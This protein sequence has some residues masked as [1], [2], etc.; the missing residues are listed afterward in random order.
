MNKKKLEIRKAILKDS[1]G[2]IEV[3]MDSAVL[4]PKDK[5]NKE[6]NKYIINGLK[7]KSFFTLVAEIDKK[8]VGVCISNI[9]R[10]NKISADL[11]D[12]YILKK[13][14][15]K[16]IGAR[17]LEK[18]YKELKKRDVKYLGL[19]SEN[20]KKTLNFYKKQGFQIGRLIRRCDK[21]L[22]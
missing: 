20:N 17:L 15:N 9:G 3:F 4:N 21:I 11:V 6:L 18:L 8:I 14:R 13:C 2:I 1:K 10:I 12:I 16:K 22:K 7:E 19:Y 5:E